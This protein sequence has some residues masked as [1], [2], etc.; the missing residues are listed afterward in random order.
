MQL[1]H[2]GSGATTNGAHRDFVEDA[3]LAG[4]LITLIKNS[5]CES[6]DYRNTNSRIN[7]RDYGLFSF[8]TELLWIVLFL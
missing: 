5:L 6:G 3:C 1:K 8:L 2:I 4:S 7:G